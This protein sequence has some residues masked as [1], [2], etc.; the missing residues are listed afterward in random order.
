MMNFNAAAREVCIVRT[1]RTNTPLQA[2]TL[3]NNTV[4]ME[5]ARFLA[6]R[7]LQTSSQEWSARVADAFKETCGRPPTDQEHA[8]LQKATHGFLRKF[9]ADSKSAEQLLSVGETSR[10]TSLPAVDHAALT[11]TASLIMNLDETITKE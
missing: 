5:S 11:M 9:R 4:F 3:M 8:I 6:Q 7:I 10:D 2:L 1:E